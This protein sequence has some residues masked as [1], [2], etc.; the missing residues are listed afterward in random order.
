MYGLCGPSS[1]FIISTAIRLTGWNLRVRRWSRA[2]MYLGKIRVI[3]RDVEGQVFSVPFRNHHQAGPAEYEV[4]AREARRKHPSKG[5]QR[6]S[7]EGSRVR[8]IDPVDRVLR[9]PALQDAESAGGDKL[10][11]GNSREKISGENFPGQLH[12]PQGPENAR[13]AQG[14]QLPLED[15]PEE[16]A[17]AVQQQ[18]RPVLPALFRF[19]KILAV[20][21]AEKKV[22]VSGMETPL[23]SPRQTRPAAGPSPGRSSL[24]GLDVRNLVLLEDRPPEGNKRVI[25][26]PSLPYSTPELFRQRWRVH[27]GMPE[28]GQ[29]IVTP[30]RVGEDPRKLH[31]FLESVGRWT[32]LGLSPRSL[33]ENLPSAGPGLTRS[34]RQSDGLRPRPTSGLLPA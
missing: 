10:G 21:R 29:K 14:R 20:L 27:P 6:N 1:P 24:R 11:P 2:P 17:V 28:K 33:R 8:G 23:F 9:K 22:P 32:L 12:D 3:G 15:F 4:R 34:R 18:S 30:V 19:Q 7:A 5:F 16:D 25:R 13:P 26:H 31:L